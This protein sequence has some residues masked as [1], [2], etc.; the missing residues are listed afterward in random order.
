MK[1]MTCRTMGG[2]CDMPISAE[3]SSAMA[4]KMTEHVMKVHPDVAE[5][6]ANMTPAEHE[7]WEDQFH[8]DWN[9]AQNHE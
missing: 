9:N 1:T 5:R 4:E 7:K 6:M 3:T 8:K 2:G